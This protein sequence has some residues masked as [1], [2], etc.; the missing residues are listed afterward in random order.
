MQNLIHALLI[1]AVLAGPVSLFGAEKHVDP[2]AA[3]RYLMA[4]GYMPEISRSEGTELSEVKDIETLNKL[5]KSL[6]EKLTKASHAPI[7][8]L[9]DDAKKCSLCDF[10]PDAKLELDDVVPPYR[11]LRTFARFLN[12]GAWKAIEE[13]K[14]EIGAELFIATFRFGDDFENNGP[15]ISYMLGCNVREL[16]LTS[17]ETFLSQDYKPEAKKAII[18]YLKSLPRPAFPL[19]EGILWEKLLGEKILTTLSKNP[20]N[21]VELLPE[22]DEQ[23][24]IV[25]NS[26][27]SACCANQ[28]VI[29][30]ALEMAGMDGIKFEK[31]AKFSDIQNKLL[32]EKYILK[33]FECPD[34]GQ[35]R[36]E[37]TSDT[38]FIVSC[39]CGAN[40]D[41]PKSET[42]K[43][44]RLEN[45]KLVEKAIE[46]YS[47]GKFAKD[48]NELN[49]Y[50]DKVL[51]IDPLAE[52][53]LETM[54]KLTKNYE[55][56]GNYIIDN[57][58]AN[59]F[60]TFKEQVELQKRI[61]ALIK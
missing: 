47:S 14:H 16:A 23:E 15:L 27:E 59:F 55:S 49:E 7:K 39:S 58:M 30:G 44:T 46:Y 22:E 1:V 53:A 3:L 28:R 52:G 8:K 50:I 4:I 24:T 5:P 29:S 10:N 51:A 57:G 37:F 42:Q 41:T 56:R 34:K 26:K 36:V 35:Y 19:K 45:P 48:K 13:G 31:S 11:L 38:D 12:A 33:T 43:T 17:M 25:S 60:R 9:L 40:P 2:N 61:D 32:T 21:L 20:K 18:T 6:K 54:E